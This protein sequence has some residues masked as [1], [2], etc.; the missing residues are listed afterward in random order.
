[1]AN[2]HK[3][4]VLDDLPHGEETRVWG[5]SAHA[6]QTDVIRAHAPKVKEFTQKIG[7]RHYTL[8]D[9]EQ[10]RNRIK[11]KVRWLTWILSAREQTTSATNRC[12]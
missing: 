2:A 12:V 5:N 9:Q 3:S 7:S 6:G 11:S 8:S 4:Q 1:M 10:S